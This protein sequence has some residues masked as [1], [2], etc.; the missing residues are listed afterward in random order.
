MPDDEQPMIE[1]EHK[2]VVA[3][4]VAQEL[5][6]RC[7]GHLAQKLYDRARPIAYTRTLYLDTEA[8]DYHRGASSPWSSR[9]RV[10][11]YASARALDEAPTL[12]GTAVL[13]LKRSN[14]L[15]R[16]KWRVESEP[17]ALR[18]MLVGGAR[19]SVLPLPLANAD[20]RSGILHP[21]MTTWY[22][23]LSFAAQRIR[24]T[25]DESV[26]FCAPQLPGDAGDSAEPARVVARGPRAVL[27]VKL[28]GDAPAWLREAMA[29]LGRH[30]A[31]SKFHT[32]MDHVCG[33]QPPLGATLALPS[34]DVQPQGGES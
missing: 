27:E 13:E 26:S 21:Q 19:P 16:R 15:R 29:P 2:Y 12:T 25:V 10:R 24:I 34:I 22:R 30:T 11:E 23:R 4:E 1:R 31:F 8:R 6:Q 32:G 18:A 28:H 33:V 14:G 20:D 5:I 17:V 3:T 7:N 9:V